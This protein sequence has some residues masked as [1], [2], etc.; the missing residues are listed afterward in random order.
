MPHSA[1]WLARLWLIP[2]VLLLL[3]TQGCRTQ[4]HSSTGDAAFQQDLVIA[5]TLTAHQRVPTYTPTPKASPTT[6]VT[7][8]PTP[9][10][11]PVSP[12][13]TPKPQPQVRTN[14]NL[15]GGPGTAYPIIDG[16]T[17]GDLVDVEAQT[18]D[19][20]WLLLRNGTWLYAPLVD[21]LPD[22][23]PLTQDLPPTPI[24]PATPTPSAAPDKIREI[25]D[26][27]AKVDLD[28]V[29]RLLP[30]VEFLA[31]KPVGGGGSLVHAAIP[32]HNVALVELL[33]THPDADVNA[34][35]DF[36]E[37]P[38]HRCARHGTEAMAE[39]LLAHGADPNIR[40]SAGWTPLHETTINSL[41][42]VAAVLLAHGADPNVPLPRS[43]ETPLHWAVESAS[44]PRQMQAIL[45]HP[46][47]D[48]E[49]KDQNSHTPLHYAAAMGK[50]SV[51]K[52]LL[53][54][55]ASIKARNENGRTPLHR[56]AWFG[57]HDVMRVLLKH[58]HANPDVRD[59]EGFTPLHLA[60]YRGHLEA[61]LVLLA[62]D[63]DPTILSGQGDEP[64]RTAIDMARN[65]GHHNIVELLRPISPVG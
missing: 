33:L 34:Q 7:A 23:L 38:L 12:T 52:A 39:F 47:T 25:T 31:I 58:S 10:P 64:G 22:N 63:A 42:S 60:A 61:A 54:Q 55:G 9:S 20:T 45:T 37:T 41:N 51:V 62:N 29:K 26:A 32:H 57:Q 13:A 4:R 3:T 44:R 5:P 65:A 27:V 59:R 24:P 36:G 17:E 11:L 19:G 16:L 8:S 35:D 18:A 43:G 14:A 49:A 40:D 56:A 2:V 1:R 21:H 53:E 48:L 15:R 46:D 28:T 6:A 50:T 30:Q